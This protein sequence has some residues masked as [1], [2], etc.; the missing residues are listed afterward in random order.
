MT[1][2]E[3][4]TVPVPGLPAPPGGRPRMISRDE[5]GELILPTGATTWSKCYV[6]PHNTMVRARGLVPVNDAGDRTH[7][8]W[9]CPRCPDSRQWFSAKAK[10]EPFCNTHRK[11]LRRVDG[12]ARLN[13]PAVPWGKVWRAQKHRL[14]AAGLTAGLGVAGAVADAA[15]LPWA[16][17]AAQFAAVPACVAG[18]WWLTRV[19]LTRRAIKA[20]KV[21]LRDEVGG[22]RAHKLIGRRSRCVAYI[23]A[24]AGVWVEI[25]DAVNLDVH[26]TDGGF[27]LAALF[28]LG[29]VGSR[30]YLRWVDDRRRRARDGVRNVPDAGEGQVDT[31][32]P[33]SEVELLR[34]YVLERW[35]KVS[36]KGRVLHGTRLEGIQPSVGGW[37]ATIVADD[38][39]DLDPEKFDMPEPVRKIA[40]A[41]N[42]GTSMVS[43][44]ADP[45]D[46]NR[47]MILVQ[48]ISPLR[49]GRDWDGTG[50]DLDT[51]SAETMTLEDGGRGKHQFWR[52][53]WGAVMELI[54]GCTGSG[55]S[56][57]VNL[58][59]SLE[60]ASGRVVSWVGDPQMGQSLGDIRDGVDWFAPTVEEILIMLRCAV[61]VMLA[62]NVLVTRMRV[63]ETRPNGK[64]VER[65]VKYIDVTPDFPLLSV[66]I[67]EAHLP[68][69]D[70]DHG[71][72]IVKLLALLS[73]SGRKANVKV[74]LVVQ[75]PL[76][77]ELKDSVL[78]SQ[79]ASGLVTVFRTADRLTGKAAW[80]G[81]RM[82]GDPSALPAEWDEGVTAAG[83]GYSSNTAR[84]RMRADYPGDVYDLMNSG[85]ALGLEAAVLGTAGAA[86]A[87]RW[88]RL[89]AFDSM[90][91]AEL[92]GAGIPAGLFG[93]QDTDTDA[94]KAVGG[95]EAILKF[96]ADR[97]LDDDREP[98][99][100]GDLAA[101][102]RDV[103]RTRACTNACNRLVAD[104]MLS[105]DNGR[106]ALTEA[107]AEQLGLLDEVPV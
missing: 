22:R 37:S 64:V 87:D 98:V 72:A 63:T 23:T 47:A 102:V 19:Y 41:Y 15:D 60:R 11:P 91:P 54:A 56:E 94:S 53:G 30:P 43:I 20:G 2:T 78:R 9:E 74:R 10:V 25:A 36:A 42:V 59:L 70:P 77:S 79:L 66:T 95:R 90:D 68:M 85:D 101:A 99:S 89:T 33:P 92:L 83:V 4:P 51:G 55:K 71:K 21:D 27:A 35:G 93:G 45:L 58:L 16:G 107:G 5:D 76:L 17:E 40:R 86:Y 28:G 67:D 50:I 29:V 80:P 81:G 7:L 82:P 88:K 62:R 13:L 46:A 84:M 14:V 57:Y 44:I 105:N 26:S 97:W 100:F 65:R 18:S 8:E 39:S 12:R 38:N 34:A 1:T 6:G 31:T 52:P 69:N 96:F 49:D 104:F 103:V 75:S 24:A 48:A 73:K 106:Y 32:P 3:R 61:M